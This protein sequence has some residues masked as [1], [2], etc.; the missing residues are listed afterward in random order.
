MKTTLTL[1]VL[2]ATLISGPASASGDAEAGKAKSTTCAACHGADGN[3]TS[4]MFPKLAGQHPDYLVHALM[5][6]KSGK[7]KNAIMNGMASTLSEQD[8]DDLAVYFGQQ[9]GLRTKY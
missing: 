4:S 6:Y 5:D 8:M 1:S 7:R 2:A 3:S 9:N